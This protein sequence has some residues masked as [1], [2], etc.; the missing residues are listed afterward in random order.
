MTA[1]TNRP[2]RLNVH[3]FVA[4]ALTAAT[5]WG[6]LVYRAPEPRPIPWPDGVVVSENYR[7]MSLPEN[8]GP[9]EALTE[10]NA[11]SDS[12][13]KALGLGTS[14][15]NDR[16]PQRCSG[17]YYHRRFV[18]TRAAASSPYKIWQLEVY[19]YTGLR[20]NVPHV[21]ERCLQAGGFEV[22]DR[23]AA[24]FQVPMARAPWGDGFDVRRVHYRLS[25]PSGLTKGEGAEYYVF[26]L[27]G[28]PEDK[29]EKVR[30][31][32]SSPLVRYAYFAK[33]QFAPVAGGSAGIKDTAEADAAAEDFL[34]YFLPMILRELPSSAA[35][36]QLKQEDAQR[37][38]RTQAATGPANDR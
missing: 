37:T 26:S 19:Y 35:I 14:Y 18:D 27:N 15:D 31:N 7:L 30:A 25:D 33:I 8:V 1:P 11:F 16:R 9:F 20:D 22:L 3:F 28:A 6:V 13:L 24:K 2:G 17:W 5:A 4:V 32:L 36:E 29:W 10:A 12:D 21:P 38:E 34:N 23:N